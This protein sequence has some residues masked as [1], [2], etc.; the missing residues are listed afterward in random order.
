MLEKLTE[1][2]SQV[3]LSTGFT[4]LHWQNILMLGVGC[5]FCYLAI[6]KEYEPYELLPIGLGC[7]LINLPMHQMGNFF[8]PLI[9]D[10]STK[11]IVK[12]FT[13]NSGALGKSV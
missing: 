9:F 11:E 3:L 12:G 10:E 13:Q 2:I 7:I 4:G 1:V 8:A 5:V 6:V